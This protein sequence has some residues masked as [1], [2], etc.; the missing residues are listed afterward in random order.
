MG[1]VN[2][3][4]PPLPLNQSCPAFAHLCF[5]V[6]IS[7]DTPSGF[8]TADL[9]KTTGITTENTWIELGQNV[10]T[11]GVLVQATGAT[12][13][14]LGAGLNA[15]LDSSKGRVSFGV[16]GS[17]LMT[18][19]MSAKRVEG[20]SGAREFIIGLGRNG[21][22]PTAL[23]QPATT[24]ANTRWISISTT[25]IISLQADETISVWANQVDDGGGSAACDMEFCTVHLTAV[26]I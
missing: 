13:F 20:S 23:I 22:P 15:K 25:A 10:T 11:S 9:L 8:E 21:N 17:F 16:G 4:G 7:D 12:K 1:N 18:M 6:P 19:S 26:R 3:P 5:S 2:N 14:M 24:Q